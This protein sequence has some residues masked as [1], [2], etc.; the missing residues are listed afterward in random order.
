MIKIKNYR[1]KIFNYFAGA[2]G[3]F[4]LSSLMNLEL[5]LTQTHRIHLNTTFYGIKS[6]ESINNITQRNIIL[7]D[8][9]L[10]EYFNYINNSNFILPQSTHCVTL[11]STEKLKILENK[12]TIY[13][14]VVEPKY[15]ILISFL[16]AIKNAF[17]D[18][19]TI[20]DLDNAIATV[21]PKKIETYANF[22][23]KYHEHI[24]DKPYISLSFEKLFYPP[25]S[26]YIALYT[27][28]NGIAPDIA[29][30]EKKLK[31]AELPKNMTIL[32]V[33]LEI[34]VDNLTVKKL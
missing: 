1:N 16:S 19:E 22:V 15:Y 32:G 34:D 31:Q 6:Y 29:I 18:A 33:E 27:E 26:D 2:R 10:D 4:L 11:L 30:Y 21:G 13:Q 7:G 28:L 14:I 20:Q 9:L 3:D 17:A 25:Y 8:K 23:K 24:K 12:Y 5:N